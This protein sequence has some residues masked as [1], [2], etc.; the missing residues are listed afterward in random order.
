VH[1]VPVIYCAI[2]AQGII[3]KPAETAVAREQLCKRPL[4]GNGSIAIMW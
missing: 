3:V 2:F 4:V 1:F